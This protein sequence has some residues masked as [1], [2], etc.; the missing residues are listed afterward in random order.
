[1]FTG[2]IEELGR[3][4]ALDHREG[5]ARLEIAA[6]TVLADGRARWLGD[7]LRGMLIVE[8]DTDEVTLLAAS[9]IFLPWIG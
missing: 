2:I 9:E 6:T 5:G 7:D 4:R 1:M 3:V 8:P